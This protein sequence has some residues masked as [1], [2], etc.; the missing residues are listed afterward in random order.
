MIEKEEPTMAGKPE[1]A[2]AVEY[3]KDIKAAKRF[4]VEVMGF[5]VAREAPEFIQFKE[6]F[7]VATD[8]SLDGSNNL[9]LYWT[10]DDVQAAFKD[11]SK[12][13]EVT[14]PLTEKPFGKVFGVK[15]PSGQPRYLV[16]F[17]KNRPS[18]AAE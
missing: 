13:A 6:L 4:Y 17:A 3:V 11:I 18:K 5:E 15:G 1:F 2:F 12:K 8:E 9:E 16:E 7:A 10:I 14:L